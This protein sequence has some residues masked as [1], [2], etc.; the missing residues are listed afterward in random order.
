MSLIWQQ[1]QTEGNLYLRPIPLE[2]LQLLKPLIMR[3]KWDLCCMFSISS[4]QS[5]LVVQD[6]V[7]D[8]TWLLTW[9]QGRYEAVKSPRSLGSFLYLLPLWIYS[10]FDV[11]LTS[12]LAWWR[13]PQIKIDFDCQQMNFVEEIWVTMRPI[14]EDLKAKLWIV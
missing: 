7:N 14:L 12:F 9:D 4:L 11:S 13:L 8:V 3:F 1:Q 2:A 10:W 6:D 5:D